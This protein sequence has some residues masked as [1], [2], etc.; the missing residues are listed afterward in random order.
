M[1]FGHGEGVR[2]AE[3]R[4]EGPVGGDDG[5][6][7]FAELDAQ[8][9]RGG[10]ELGDRGCRL[11]RAP[12][13]AERLGEGDPGRKCA[14]EG[15][16][17]AGAEVLSGGVHGCGDGGRGGVRGEGLAV[18]PVEQ[19]V[20]QAGQVRLCWSVGGGWRAEDRAGGGSGQGC[21]EFSASHRVVS[22]F[23]E[24]GMRAHPSG[25]GSV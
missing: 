4:G 23:A 17:S 7:V 5:Q 9:G 3:C 18:L 21:Q 25:V 13:V 14:S 8:A 24:Q 22:L 10:V 20:F 19:E 6:A 11:L 1:G 2:A 12:V 16:V 15:V